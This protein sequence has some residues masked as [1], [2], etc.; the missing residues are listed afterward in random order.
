NFPSEVQAVNHPCP[1]GAPALVADTSPLL[2]SDTKYDYD[3]QANGVAPISGNPTETDVYSNGDASNSAPHWVQ[4]LRD[5]YDSYGRLLTDENS[6]ADTTSFWYCSKW[7]G[8]TP[9]CPAAGTAGYVQ[10][11]ATTQS[12]IINPLTTSSTAT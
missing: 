11:Y 5:T 4:Q 1:A 8:A 6:R 12:S 7:S 2:V 10:G 9:A 3:G